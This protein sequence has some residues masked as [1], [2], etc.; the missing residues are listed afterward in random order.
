MST[1]GLWASQVS[2]AQPL[3][4][5]YAKIRK[6]S[7]DFC[8]VVHNLFYPAK[9]KNMSLTKVMFVAY[10]KASTFIFGGNYDKIFV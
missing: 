10:S 4:I 5:I 9:R 8:E 2:T 3:K 6:M 7:T 1:L